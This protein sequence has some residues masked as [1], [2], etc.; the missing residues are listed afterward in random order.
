MQHEY[1]SHGLMFINHANNNMIIRDLLTHKSIK[2]LLSLA[3][4]V[5]WFKEPPDFIQDIILEDAFV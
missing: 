4:K 1:L 5:E 2:I 3:I